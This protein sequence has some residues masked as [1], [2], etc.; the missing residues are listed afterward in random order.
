MTEEKT[1]S[2]IEDEQLADLVFIAE[3]L[4]FRGQSLSQEQ[5][6]EFLSLVKRRMGMAQM[7]GMVKLAEDINRKQGDKNPASAFTE[8]IVFCLEKG[9]TAIAFGKKKAEMP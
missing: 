3:D 9:L 7:V 8:A 4:Y 1:V 6:K 5:I 2:E